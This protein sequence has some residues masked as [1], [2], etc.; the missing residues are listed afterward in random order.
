MKYRYG[1]IDNAAVIRRSR[2]RTARRVNNALTSEG[3]RP[4]QTVEKI[5]QAQADLQALV[6]AS[7][8]V[9]VDDAT[10]EGF[11]PPSSEWTVLCTVRIMAPADRQAGAVQA[12]GTATMTANSMDVESGCV[13]RLLVDNRQIASVAMSRKSAED[14]QW[15]GL[16]SGVI[17][18]NNLKPGDAITVVLQ[19]RAASPADWPKQESNGADL[20]VQASFP[21]ISTTTREGGE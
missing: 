9:V 18:L 21:A 5:T 6:N 8:N 14:D 7:L 1:T 12:T 4:F 16:V 15:Y 20:T 10:V 13:L 17:N 2:Q 11:G 19:Y 3:T